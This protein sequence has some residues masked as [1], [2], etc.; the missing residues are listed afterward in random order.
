MPSRS[1]RFS[2]ISWRRCVTKTDSATLVVAMNPVYFPWLRVWAVNS[3]V[4]W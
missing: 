1:R 4:L 3:E 2:L